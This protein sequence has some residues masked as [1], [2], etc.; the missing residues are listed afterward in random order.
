M[1]YGN[2]TV[3]ASQTTAGAVNV[4]TVG[5]YISQSFTTAVGQT[6][7][8]QVLLRVSG[9]GPSAP[10]VLNLS[11]YADD[12]ATGFPTGSALASVL[13]PSEYIATSGTW[14]TFPLV[15]SVTASTVYHLVTAPVG[16]VTNHYQWLQSNQV[17]GAALSPDGVTWTAQSYGLTYQVLDT[18]VTYG[19][20][21]LIVE[22]DGTRWTSLSYG[23]T[24]NLNNIIEF[25][26]GQTSVGYMYSSRFVTYTNGLQTGVS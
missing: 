24:G 14:V 26:V 20:P 4:S 21:T 19:Q 7:I 13:V 23:S 6:A 18:T 5:Q 1:V 8:G 16:T 12:P 11:L 22:D 25:T 17:S 10:P 9:V 15:A 3:K 2:G